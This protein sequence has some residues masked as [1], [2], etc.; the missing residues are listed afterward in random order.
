MR[1]K[2]VGIIGIA[3]LLA[4]LIVPAAVL[5]DAV[6]VSIDAPAVVDADSDFTARVDIVN[7]ENFNAGQYEVVFDDTVLRLDGVGAGQIDGTAIP[8]GAWN[9]IEAG[10]ARVV[11]A[12]GGVAGATGDG[13]L[14]DL[15]FHVIGDA[16]DASDIDLENG[17]LGDNTATEIEAT[18]EGDTVTVAGAPPGAVTVSIDAPAEV[19]EDSDFTAAVDIVNVVNFDA[20][21]YEVVFDDTV[22]Q[23]DDVTA[24]DIAGTEIPVGVFNEIA[25]GR[26]AVVQNVPGLAG[27]TGDGTLAE[28]QF[29][30]IGA[31]G[32]ASDI[33]LEDGLLVD[34]TATEIAAIWLGGAVDV[35]PAGPVVVE[36]TATGTLAKG[37][38]DFIGT[39]PAGATELEITL[40]T[41]ASP[42]PDMDLELYDGATLAIGWH[43]EIDSAPGG[44]YEGDEFGYSGYG[45]GEESITAGGPLGRAYD[46]E[47]FGYRAGTYTVTVYYE[48]PGGVDVT[49]PEID[50]E[51]DPA[52]PEVGAA[53][54]VTV[55]AADPSGVFMVY[56]FVSSPAPEGLFVGT[57]APQVNYV[58]IIGVVV[59][60][61]DEASLTFTPGWA[62]TYT[63]EAWAVDELGN[64][65]PEGTP[66]TED[67]EVAA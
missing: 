47:V 40:S 27:V 36:F 35:I 56:F 2:L 43:G 62:G 10:R 51:V 32:D 4:A 52:A 63:V 30:V 31:P 11:Q 1:K 57:V 28:L 64:M 38:R 61:S 5:A 60:F 7:V 18:W 65:T 6:N 12:V 53:V 13:F 33:D 55:T 59:S 16:G 50:I 67:F 19:L 41:A 26:F 49:P 21:Q 9:L 58:D 45:G 24:G 54:T 23:L 17:L 14:A 42:G 39:I 34:N 15:F 66:V 22:L 3:A 44:T 46:L 37:L 48:L 29:H 20:A 25:P 8:V